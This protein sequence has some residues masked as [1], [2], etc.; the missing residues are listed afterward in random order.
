MIDDSGYIDIVWNSA[1]V[2]SVMRR[3]KE[4]EEEKL[5]GVALGVVNLTATMSPQDSSVEIKF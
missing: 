1:G 5:V 4:A 2:T 3:R